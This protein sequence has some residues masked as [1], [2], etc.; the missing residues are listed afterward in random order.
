M[1]E[2]YSALEAP[3]PEEAS[4]HL[5]DVPVIGCAAVARHKSIKLQTHTTTCKPTQ[6]IA[7]YDL[8]LWKECSH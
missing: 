2:L 8:Y 3:L 1:G 4:H 6:N 5:I 7:I